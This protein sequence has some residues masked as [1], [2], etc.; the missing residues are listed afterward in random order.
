MK[1][2]YQL[3]HDD[4]PRLSRSINRIR[5]LLPYNL[6]KNTRHII[7]SKGVPKL[8]ALFTWNGL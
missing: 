6:A 8:K 1:P 7:A 3:C 4:L 2:P 5:K